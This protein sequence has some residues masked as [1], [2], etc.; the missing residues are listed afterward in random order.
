[1]RLEEYF[2]EDIPPYAILSGTWG[3]EEVTLHEWTKLYLRRDLEK[4][5]GNSMAG[6]FADHERET[7][8]QKSGYAKI[9]SCCHQ[10]RSSNIDYIWADTCCI[11]KTSG[12]ELSEAINSML[13]WYQNTILCYAFLSDVPPAGNIANEDSAFRQS[14][15]FTR[16]W[17]LQELL[18]PT[19]LVFFDQNWTRLHK[20]TEIPSLLSNITGIPAHYSSGHRVPKASIAQKM[21]WVSH[22][23]TTRREDIAYCLL[24]IFEVNMPL[25]YGEGEK[26]FTRLQEEIVKQTQDQTILAWGL[27]LPLDQDFSGILARSLADFDG[28]RNLVPFTVSQFN[29][30]SQ[31]TNKGL[32]IRLPVWT[33]GSCLDFVYA[34]IE[35]T[36]GKAVFVIPLIPLRN[37]VIEAGD[38][39]WRPP[40]SI[41][42][43]TV[44]EEFIFHKKDPELESHVPEGW[45]EKFVTIYLK[46]DSALDVLEY[47]VS[48]PRYLPFEI[49]GIASLSPD[50]S[51]KEIYTYNYWLEGNRVFRLYPKSTLH[52]FSAGEVIF[53]GIF[54]RFS[55]TAKRADTVVG[56]QY[57]STN[58]SIYPSP[59]EWR[60]YMRYTIVSWEHLEE[61]RQDKTKKV[62]K[63]TELFW[64]NP[65]C[66]L[67]NFWFSLPDPCTQALCLNVKSARPWVFR[68]YIP[69]QKWLVVAGAPPQSRTL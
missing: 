65:D 2:N 20:K 30:P 15:W 54:L 5:F 55:F 42:I 33:N 35:C 31:I 39:F 23:K 61:R 57:H 37:K 18:A 38:D 62:S 8:Q 7:T 28:C 46:R 56:F 6:T 50:I 26:A 58:C 16:G 27:D 34:G 14:R 24:G 43:R 44:P 21:A 69:D 13:R 29:S 10:A 48:R 25:L 60:N 52:L 49:Y 59:Q 53:H 17:T 19:E 12:A 63:L 41:P 9:V 67:E 66:D 11:D 32:Q 68:L 3:K 4:H 22:R 51:L 36:D 47:N 45:V 1:M 40:S 64:E